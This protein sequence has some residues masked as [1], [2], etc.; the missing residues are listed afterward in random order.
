MPT[1]TMTRVPRTSK[2][3]FTILQVAL[4]LVSLTTLACLAI[5]FWFGRE[6]VTLDN[7]AVLLAE[8]LREVQN[9]AAFQRSPLRVVF[10][11]DGGGY[12]VRDSAGRLA[13]AAIGGRPFLR[14]YD[15]DAVFRGVRVD[16]IRTRTEN[17][18]LYGPRGLLLE[19]AEIRLAFE[20]ETRTLSV[21]AGTGR[22]E[23]EGLER[24]EWIDDGR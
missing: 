18:M 11:P 3:G 21:E 6:E 16:R 20:G 23:V 15:R 9:R 2:A 22:I 17:E 1:E 10:H 19:G 13:V 4:I 7:A 12:E 24:R 8:D 14:E 5:P